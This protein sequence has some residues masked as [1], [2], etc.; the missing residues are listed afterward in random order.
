[1]E[2][3]AA[4]SSW[5]CPTSILAQGQSATFRLRCGER[6]VD[7][8][9]INHQGYFYAYVNR[10][11]HVGTPLDL[12]P[13]EFFTEDGCHL[14]CATHGAVY[15]PDTGECI[16]GPCPGAFLTRLPVALDGENLVVACPEIGS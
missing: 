8:F 1:V 3:K 4:P 14:I 5:S 16:A 11:A 12:W 10:C 15:R 9:V 13:N 6:T 7:G 2:E